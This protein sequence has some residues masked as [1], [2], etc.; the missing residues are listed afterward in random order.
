[1]QR[2]LTLVTMTLLVTAPA[3]LAALLLRPR[4]GGRGRR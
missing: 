1:M 3:V 2:G 4:S